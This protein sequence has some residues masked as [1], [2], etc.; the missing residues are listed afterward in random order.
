MPT[1]TRRFTFDSAHRILGHES[2][3]RFLHGHR[4]VA[5]VTVSAP[6]LDTLGRVVDFSV[7]KER[8]GKWIEDNWDHNILL[9]ENDPLLLAEEDCMSGTKPDKLALSIFGDKNPFIFIGRNP[10]A[11]N[12]AM[13]LHSIAVVWLPDYKIEQVR[14]WETPNCSA[15]YPG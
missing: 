7:L 5:E 2:K 15:T 9:H 3:C 10:T 6:E 1:I 8:V 11:E 14:V 13:Y 4:Y 12:I